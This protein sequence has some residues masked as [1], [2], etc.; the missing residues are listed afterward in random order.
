MNTDTNGMC[1]PELALNAEEE[2]GEEEEEEKKKKKNITK[3][4]LFK[5]TENC[6]S[7]KTEKIQVKKNLIFLIFLLKT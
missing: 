4:H 1:I 3:T 6:T 7:K 5:Y 2:E